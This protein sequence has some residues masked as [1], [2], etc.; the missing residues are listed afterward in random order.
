[1]ITV[2]EALAACLALTRVLPGERIALAEA[3]GRVLAEPVFATRDQP[4]FAASAMD[5]YAVRIAMR[6]PARG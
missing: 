6:F 1:V 5:G 2:E 3:A 4:P